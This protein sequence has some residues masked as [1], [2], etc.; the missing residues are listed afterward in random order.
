M[1]AKLTVSAA[2]AGAK[3]PAKASPAPPKRA[4]VMRSRR[5]IRHLPI[6]V[7]SRGSYPGCGNS[8][9]CRGEAAIARIARS[10]KC[11]APFIGPE[12]EAAGE[13]MLHFSHH[14]LGQLLSTY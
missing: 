11:S 9:E 12:G 7:S 10:V 3:R 5:P 1:S 13:E 6:M 14:E 4:D 8:S 2:P